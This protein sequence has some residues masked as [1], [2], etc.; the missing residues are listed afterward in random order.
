MFNQRVNVNW[1]VDFH[2][3][4]K[5]IQMNSSKLP[6]FTIESILNETI[7]YSKLF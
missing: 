6:K 4:F 2:F 7:F 1:E 5:E 3:E